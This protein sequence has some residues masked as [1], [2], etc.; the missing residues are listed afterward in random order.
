MSLIRST[1]DHTQKMQ[2]AID[3]RKSFLQRLVESSH[4]DLYGI[5][6]YDLI[7]RQEAFRDIE[8][9]EQFIGSEEAKVK[10]I[11]ERNKR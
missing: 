1:K 10:A 4:G 7:Q 3:M 9:A 2:G 11:T 6:M 5:N 8:E